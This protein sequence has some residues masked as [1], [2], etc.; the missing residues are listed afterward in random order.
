V[1]FHIHRKNLETHAHRFAPLG[2]EIQDKVVQL[3]EDSPTLELLFRFIYPQ[4]PPELK[5]IPFVTIASLA[6][7]AEKYKVFFAIYVCQTHF[8]YL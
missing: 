8:R 7:A 6:E 5:A 3:T 4:P 2:L 1:L